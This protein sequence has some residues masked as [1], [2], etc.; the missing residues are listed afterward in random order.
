MEDI[1]L[2]SLANVAQDRKIDFVP[3]LVLDD[4]DLT[5]A[6]VHV[7]ELKP[8]DVTRP[9]PGGCRQ[10]DDGIIP[11]A[12]FA[13]GVNDTQDFFNLPLPNLKKSNSFQWTGGNAEHGFGERL[14]R[15]LARRLIPGKPAAGKVGLG[16]RGEMLHQPNVRSLQRR[17][18][19][20]RSLQRRR[21]EPCQ[22]RAYRNPGLLRNVRAARGNQMRQKDQLPFGI[23]RQERIYAT[24]GNLT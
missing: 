11:F 15:R 12:P 23:G 22:R 8:D 24:S 21:N 3:G 4:S 1:I 9:Q 2:Q 17:I 14:T 5:P 16:R 10:Q 13:P 19:T 18:Q 6:P 20:E 7:R